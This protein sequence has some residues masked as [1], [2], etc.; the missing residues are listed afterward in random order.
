MNAKSRDHFVRLLEIDSLAEP[1]TDELSEADKCLALLR[2]ANRNDSKQFRTS[3]LQSIAVARKRLAERHVRVLIAEKASLK[4]TRSELISR[5]RQIRDQIREVDTDLGKYL[6]ELPGATMCAGCR[7]VS[8]VEHIV[9]RRSDMVITLKDLEDSGLKECVQVSYP[10]LRKR[11]A[12]EWARY[13]SGK[14][15]SRALLQQFCSV[16]LERHPQLL[17]KVTVESDVRISDRRRSEPPKGT[18]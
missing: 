4:K 17:G 8:V 3:E 11:V 15:L 6:K 9:V 5:A 10:R 1:T 16:F 12:L 14:N 13:S 18:S 2:K 7:I